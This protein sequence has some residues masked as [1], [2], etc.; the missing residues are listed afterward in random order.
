MDKSLAKHIRITPNT[1]EAILTAYEIGLIT[2]P[3]R[4]A[5]LDDIACKHETRN[6][7]HGIWKCYNCGE[8]FFK[9]VD[10]VA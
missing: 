7:G 5:L 4:D 9:E 10:R 2:W 6:V 1:E 8:E 3:T